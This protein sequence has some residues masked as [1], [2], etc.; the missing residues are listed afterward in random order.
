MLFQ[1]MLFSS[2]KAGRSEVPRNAVERGAAGGAGGRQQLHP[3]D[4]VD[5]QLLVAQ[6]RH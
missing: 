6:G 4:P 2:G 1:T 5:H 3:A